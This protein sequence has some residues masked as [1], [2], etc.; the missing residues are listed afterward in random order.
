MHSLSP[1]A[2]STSC[3]DR[4]C[5]ELLHSSQLFLGSKGFTFMIMRKIYAGR[6]PQEFFAPR[7]LKTIVH[8]T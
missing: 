4:I 7:R 1:S 3:R 5:G 8:S 2:I 6:L